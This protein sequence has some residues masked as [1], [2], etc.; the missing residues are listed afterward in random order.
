MKQV[1]YFFLI[2]LILA[3]KVNTVLL[4]S[5]KFIAKLSCTPCNNVLLFSTLLEISAC[6]ISTCAKL[7]ANSAAT[8][9]FIF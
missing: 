4:I 6:C 5:S 8:I 1:N 2:A 9:T 3:S 7:L